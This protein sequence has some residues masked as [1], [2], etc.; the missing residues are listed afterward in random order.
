MRAFFGKNER[1]WLGGGAIAQDPPR[2]RNQW[3][4]QEV[5]L[6]VRFMESDYISTAAASGQLC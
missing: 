2:N 6:S 5:P 4:I 3:Q 1:I